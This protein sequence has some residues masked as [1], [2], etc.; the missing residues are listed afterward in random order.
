MRTSLACTLLFAASLGACGREPSAADVAQVYRAALDSLCGP[1]RDSSAMLVVA[2]RT[3]PL[4]SGYVNPRASRAGPELPAELIQSLRRANR[5]ESVLVNFDLLPVRQAFLDSAT[6]DRVVPRRCYTR[7]VCDAAWARFR[8]QY[9]GATGFVVVSRVGFSRDA[10]SAAL[11]VAQQLGFLEGG[12][13]VVVL[14]RTPGGWRV[15]R[16][17]NFMVY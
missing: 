8:A 1:L 11:V 4:D 9:P 16:V 5:A 12:A 2:A 17:I 10:G 14:S 15:S 3:L 13:S 7:E 6:A